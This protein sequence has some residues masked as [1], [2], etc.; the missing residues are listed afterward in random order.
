MIIR[1]KENI[2]QYLSSIYFD[3]KR[4]G[5]FGGV[6]RLYNEVEKKKKYKLIRQNTYTLHKPLRRKL[7]RN[8]VFVS[9]FDKQW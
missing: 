9:G 5:S 6:D 7:L 2:D 3:P 1:L 4:S 8:L